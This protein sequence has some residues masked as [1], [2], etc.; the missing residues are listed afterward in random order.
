G[1]KRGHWPS[2]SGDDCHLTMPG[3]IEQARK[4]IPCLFRAHDNDISH[5]ATFHGPSIVALSV[6]GIRR[7]GLSFIVI[8]GTERFHLSSGYSRHP[9]H[10]ARRITQFSGAMRSCTSWPTG[11]RSDGWVRDISTVSPARS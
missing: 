4:L 7:V 2:I 6:F 9:I 10:D 1:H 11:L 5:A 8:L 3:G